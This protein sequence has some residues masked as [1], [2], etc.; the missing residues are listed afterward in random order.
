M[1]PRIGK[2]PKLFIC[3]DQLPE[4]PRPE[5]Y[6]KL[7]WIEAGF[8]SSEPNIV[9]NYDRYQSLVYKANFHNSLGD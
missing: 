3:R 4:N 1:K 6:K 7:N 2:Q 8:V 5:D 9:S